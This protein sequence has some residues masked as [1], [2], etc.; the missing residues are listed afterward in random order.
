MNGPL[1]PVEIEDRIM[2]LSNRIASGVK[3]VT[4]RLK[5]RD[6]ARRNFDREWAACYLSAEGSIK[7]REQKAHLETMPAREEYD[8]AEA[9]YRYADRTAKALE[10]ELRALQ[11]IGASVRQMYSIAGRGEY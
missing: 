3:V 10:L 2:K 6:E 11:S 4:D 1:N 8:L 7:D 9:A 5:E